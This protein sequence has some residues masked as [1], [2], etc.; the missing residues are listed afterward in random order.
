MIYFKAD[1]GKIHVYFDIKIYKNRTIT[2]QNNEKK[3]P[4]KNKLRH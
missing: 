2:K 3:Y 4:L 1:S